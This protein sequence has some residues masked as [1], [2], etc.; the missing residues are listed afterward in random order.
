MASEKFQL[1]TLQVQIVITVDYDAPHK[2]VDLWTTFL[3]TFYNHPTR[4]FEAAAAKFEQ[5]SNQALVRL[6]RC[7]GGLTSGPDQSNNFKQVRPDDYLSLSWST[8]HGQDVVEKAV[9]LNFVNGDDGDSVWSS[10]ELIDI[11]NA[12]EEALEDA[13]GWKGLISFIRIHDLSY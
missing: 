5:P 2:F 13:L 4:F 1:E 12:L 7:E 11:K 9:V 6:D 8:G 3:T 10:V